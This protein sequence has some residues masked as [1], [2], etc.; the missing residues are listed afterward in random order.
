M[1]SLYEYSIPELTHLL[2]ER[3]KE[4]RLRANMTQKDVSD[5]SGLTMQTI[6]KFETGM[7]NNMSLG[8]F[9]LLLKSIG[10][11][12]QINEILPELP[13]SPYLYHSGEKKAQRVRHKQQ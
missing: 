10:C 5:Q 4:Y 1:A 12:D 7:I 9:M 11:I 8:T 13:E 6:S 2:G 3:F